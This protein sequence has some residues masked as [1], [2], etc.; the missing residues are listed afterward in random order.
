[1]ITAAACAK[2]N[3]G[4]RVGAAGSDGLHRLDG[5]FLSISW[6]DTLWI[7]RARE[8]QIEG[9][10]GSVVPDGERNLAWLAACAARDVAARSDRLH[11]RLRKRIPAAAGLGGGSADAAA[12]L[13]A[14]GRLFG[15]ARDDLAGLAPGLGSDVP[16]C[17]TGG[18]AL[19][20]GAGEQ[21]EPL[22]PAGGFALA[23][24]VPP[25]EVA[26]GDVYDAWDRLGGPAGP[27]IGLGHLPPTLR[28]HDP[29]VND[30]TP[31]SIHVAPS[32]AEWRDELE[33]VWARPVA[34]SGSGPALFSFFVDE[35]EAED[36]L[37]VVPP[38][39]RAAET[40]VPAPFGWALEAGG[41]G[42]FDSHG[43]SLARFD[44]GK[45]RKVVGG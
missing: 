24:V 32:I 16:F 27:R 37:G 45:W 33:A 26:T 17:F 38:G 29:L 6:T 22:E 34:L 11:L 19:V 1:M 23:V 41:E 43:R 44:D 5:L 40:A 21:V 14:T 25:V 30:L 7:E 3:L 4:L 9:D 28:D 36:A 2:V 31:A 8:D 39:A 18:L 35:L 42:P 13:G 20:R 15:V 10:G 12:A